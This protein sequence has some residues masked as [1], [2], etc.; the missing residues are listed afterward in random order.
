MTQEQIKQASQ[1]FHELR[2]YKSDAATLKRMINESWGVMQVDSLN[3]V[4]VPKLPKAPWLIRG[5]E[6][7]LSIVER[8]IIELESQLEHL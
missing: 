5:L 7:S 2:I 8:R 4:E 6:H 1:I 3:Y